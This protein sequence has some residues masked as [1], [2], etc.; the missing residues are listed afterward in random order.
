[1]KNQFNQGTGLWVNSTNL[2]SNNNSN[3]FILYPSNVGIQT[4]NPAYPLDVNGCMRV[5]INNN[6][7]NKLL[8]SWDNDILDS[9][10]T[11]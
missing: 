4:E 11:S 2:W 6:Q 5:N 10:V 3:I 7:S 1:M 8:T 9:L